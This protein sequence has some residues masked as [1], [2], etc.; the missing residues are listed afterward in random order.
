MI[1][2]YLYT[3]EKYFHCPIMKLECLQH[4]SEFLDQGGQL[5]GCFSPLSHAAVDLE[6]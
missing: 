3:L 2:Q 5:D 1:F 4:S 6:H